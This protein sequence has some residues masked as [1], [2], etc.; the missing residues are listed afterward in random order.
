MNM[1][2]SLGAAIAPMA[3]GFLLHFSN[4]NWA[5]P[6]WISGMIYLL[7]GLCWLGIDPVRAIEE[8]TV[9]PEMEHA[10]QR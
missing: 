9:T 10:E 1:M 3:I 6:F 4:R 7:G 8:Q 5:L 2:G